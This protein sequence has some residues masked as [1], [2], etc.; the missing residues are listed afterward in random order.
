MENKAAGSVIGS[1][2]AP[3][4]NSLARRYGLAEASYAI[5][6]PSLPNYMALTSGSTEGITSDCWPCVVGGANIVDQLEAAGISWRAYLEGVPSACYRGEGAGGYAAKHNPF[7]HYRD[8]AGSAKRCARLVGFGALASDLRRGTLPAFAWITPN[9]CDDT[10]DCDVATGDRFLERTV[11]PLLR[12]LGPHGFL[13]ITWDEGVDAAGCCAGQAAGGRIATIVAGPDVRPGGRSDRPLS[14]Y[15]VLA[16][17]EQALGLA[18]LGGAARAVNG[19]LDPLFSVA[20][21]LRG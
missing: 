10:H 15:G 9:L 8:V 1:R 17:I 11:P 5:T 7:I 12:E 21:R 4:A 16:T 6:H 14:H 19:T 20:P 18:R 2:D 3:Y 13:V